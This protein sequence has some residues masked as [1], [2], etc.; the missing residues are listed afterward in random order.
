MAAIG[1]STFIEIGPG[2]VL[3]GLIRRTSKEAVTQNIGSA[4]DIARWSI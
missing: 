2:Q 4:E 3:T 1:V